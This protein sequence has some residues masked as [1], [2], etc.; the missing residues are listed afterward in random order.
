MLGRAIPARAGGPEKMVELRAIQGY[1]GQISNFTNFTRTSRELEFP[2]FTTLV[3]SPAAAPSI[4]GCRD[5][6]DSRPPAS[7]SAG[8]SH[9]ASEAL[10][11]TRPLIPVTRPGGLPGPT[12]GRKPCQCAAALLRG[13]PCPTTT[14]CRLLPRSRPGCLGA[15]KGA[16]LPVGRRS[17]ASLCGGP[18]P[19]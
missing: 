7:L 9:T 15:R 19:T 17:E 11:R 6:S 16:L 14:L 10:A 5:Y 4:A 1:A 13:G 8:V 3:T 2:K 12:V 18:L